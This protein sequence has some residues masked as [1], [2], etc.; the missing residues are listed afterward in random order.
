MLLACIYTTT[1]SVP[2]MI[3]LRT[4]WFNR[5]QFS[6]LMT[7]HTEKQ[8][9][10]FKMLVFL[11]LHFFYYT[12]IVISN[13]STC[14]FPVIITGLIINH[15]VYVLQCS[16][17]ITEWPYAQHCRKSLSKGWG[18]ME[19]KVNYCKNC[20]RL[21]AVFDDREK[22]RFFVNQ[23]KDLRGDPYSQNNWNWI[24]NVYIKITSRNAFGFVLSGFFVCLFVCFFFPNTFI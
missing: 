20:K 19:Q 22:A 16:M 2:F 6:F 7:Q 5:I 9:E 8:N 21:K 18:R 15:C 24:W 14:S 11:Y 4:V 17:F 3:L 23:L 1:V 12:L 10:Q 13:N